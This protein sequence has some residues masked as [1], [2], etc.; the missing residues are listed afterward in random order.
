MGNIRPVITNF[1]AG[2][3]SPKMDG[4][5]DHTLYGSGAKELTNFQVELLGGVRRRG[6]LAHE[7]ELKTQSGPSRLIP[8]NVSDTLDFLIVLSNNKIHILDVSAGHSV[9]WVQTF[10]DP[11]MVDLEIISLSTLNTVLPYKEDEIYEVKYA[12]SIREI[13]MVH[14]DYRPFRMKF[15]SYD[16]STHE[17]ILEYGLCSFTGNIAYSPE[18]DADASEDTVISYEHFLS[19][20]RLLGRYDPLDADT[21]YTATG[22]INGHPV[23]SIQKEEVDR[24]RYAKVSATYYGGLFG[25]VKGGFS[26]RTIT[27]ATVNQIIGLSEGTNNEWKVGPSKD[28]HFFSFHGY[29]SSGT[30]LL[31]KCEEYM[32]QVT[33]PFIMHDSD[34]VYKD[35]G[36][37]VF[38]K[39]GTDTSFRIKFSDAE[40]DLVIPATGY[41]G[42]IL[43]YISVPAYK[44]SINKTTVPG[45]QILDSTATWMTPNVPYLCS[46][47]SIINGVQ[48]ISCTKR[49]LK[50][51]NSFN[52]NLVEKE[53]L[54][55]ETG[56]LNPEPIIDRDTTA[57]S[58]KIGVILTPFYK[59]D[60]NPSFVCF[61]QGRAVFGGSRTEPNVVYLSK[62]NDYFNFSFF[63]EVEYQQTELLPASQ[64]LD[65]GTPETSTTT[66]IVQQ[67]GASSA[68]RIQ[69]ATEESEAIRAAASISDLVLL[70]ATSEWV[71]P[72]GLDATNSRVMM[73]TRNGSS[74]IQPRF[75]GS[76][77]VFTT[78]SRKGLRAFRPE[79]ALKS[80]DLSQMADHMFQGQ[81]RYID[82]RQ[83]P[84]NEAYFVL[85]SGEC[86]VGLLEDNPAFYRIRL[87]GTDEIEGLAVVA[88]GDEDAVYMATRRWLNGAWVRSVERLLT[89]DDDA[90]L[91]RNYLDCSVGG[92]LDTA[93][94]EPPARFIF[95]G[96]L[97]TRVRMVIRDTATG[98]ETYGVPQLNISEEI[99][100]VLVDGETAPVPLESGDQYLIGLPFTSRLKTFRIDSQAT[101]GFK[102]QS[103][104]IHLRV[105]KSG[106]FSLKR[107]T[108]LLYNQKVSTPEDLT[109]ERVYPY[110]GSIRSEY[111]APMDTDMYVEVE[112][113]G[114]ESVGIQVIAPMIS[115]GDMI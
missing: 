59:S 109:G 43:G 106:S 41:T 25:V 63:E 51:P 55:L 38:Y 69:L 66:N 48:V 31:D 74:G 46:A 47:D 90:F 21:V 40:P 11:S 110:T 37:I 44:I 77:L 89:T 36:N 30:Y 78:N 95:G 88:A 65:P 87:D 83:D 79:A 8:W 100:S 32:D 102:K 42:S 10:V 22:S 12:Q 86:V 35:T 9:G 115:V 76:A 60:D 93:T 105:Y 19:V 114:H 49:I 81:I 80:L 107:S 52:G 4:R 108:D 67:V 53:A 97:D 24:V 112:A 3:L 85:D 111:E 2:E 61:H 99:E 57:V 56:S 62:T 18:V 71:F 50:V 64:W 7:I 27:D 94:L 98:T 5:V 82:F 6:G 14:P 84:R 54:E 26:D 96:V 70:T 92:T 72:A 23:A 73:A 34:L 75:I 68:I 103:G 104:A 15:I 29:N 113:D 58:G 101:E 28:V 91:T 17:L 1:L 33:G 13:I 45:A 39:G 20:M 16:E